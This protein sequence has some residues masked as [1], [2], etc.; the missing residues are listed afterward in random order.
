MKMIFR[1]HKIKVSKT[2]HNNNENRT[3]TETQSKGGEKRLFERENLNA[4]KLDNPKTE[5]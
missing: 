4:I 2:N 1:S 3:Q 5:L